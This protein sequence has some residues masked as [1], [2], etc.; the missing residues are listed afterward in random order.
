M[1][2]F[3]VMRAFVSFCLFYRLSREQVREEVGDEEEG[4]VVLI[5][6]DELWALFLLLT[7]VVFC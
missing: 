2:C 4:S 6:M 7:D 1:V 3:C 5:E